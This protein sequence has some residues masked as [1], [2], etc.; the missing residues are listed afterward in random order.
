LDVKKAEE[1][2]QMLKANSFDRMTCSQVNQVQSWGRS[3]GLG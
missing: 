3:G 1:M 2:A